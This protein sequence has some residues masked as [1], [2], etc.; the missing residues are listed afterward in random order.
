MEYY[1]RVP[2]L[3]VIWLETMNDDF[4][5]VMKDSLGEILNWGYSHLKTLN[6][7]VCAVP[8]AVCSAKTL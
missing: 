5:D 4:A 3:V 1:I 8:D 2:S 6:V 7:A